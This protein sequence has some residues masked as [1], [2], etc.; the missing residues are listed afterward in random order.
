MGLEWLLRGSEAGKV[1]SGGARE[2]RLRGEEGGKV[3]S[4]TVGKER[5]G[6]K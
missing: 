6:K 4:D 3:R 2:S 5:K 1:Q